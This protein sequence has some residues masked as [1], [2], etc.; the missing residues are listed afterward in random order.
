MEKTDNVAPSPSL[1]TGR[2]VSLAYALLRVT[3]GINI[4]LHGI[5]RIVAGQSTFAASLSKQ[6]A[7]T[8]LPHFAVQGFGYVLPWG[9]AIIGLLLLF[10]AGTRV[11][12]ITGALVMAML[13]F[14]TCLVQD[15]NVAGLQL[16]YSTVYFLLI[17]MMRYNRFS[18]DSLLSRNR[19]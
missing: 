19:G 5:T 10:G 15:W 4:A 11:A 9:E 3:L 14:G 18:I 2:D 1:F 8:T 16:I 17:A 6:F 13:T 7:V 12:L